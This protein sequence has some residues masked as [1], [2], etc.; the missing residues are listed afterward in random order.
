MDSHRMRALTEEAG[1]SLQDNHAAEEEAIGL[2][3]R[4]AHEFAYEMNLLSGGR[5]LTAS[6][7][8]VYARAVSISGP[9]LT[10]GYHFG[11]TDAYDFGRPFERGT[12]GQAGGSF[13]AAAGPLAFYVRAEYQHA[14]SAPALSPA[15]VN[16]ICKLMAERPSAIPRSPFPKFLQGHSMP[17]IGPNYLMP[18]PL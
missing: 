10:D 6:I 5:N 14:P 9:P 18:T 4:L 8:S 15:V 1:E 7:E 17:L 12:N 16:F 13:S 11:Q 2:Q 3:A